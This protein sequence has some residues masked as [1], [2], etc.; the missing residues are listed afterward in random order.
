MIVRFCL[1]SIFKNLRFFEPFLILY[2]L[3][4]SATGGPEL[5]YVQ[6][7]ALVDTRNYSRECWRFPP[8]QRPIDGDVVGLSSGA[9]SAMS[10]PS[11]CLPSPVELARVSSPS[12]MEE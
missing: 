4:D 3:S 10:W 5:L 6:I 7:G 1:Y 12:S 11:P 2:L 9:L 8:A